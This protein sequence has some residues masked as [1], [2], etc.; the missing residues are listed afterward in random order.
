MITNKI[1]KLYDTFL[2][3]FSFFRRHIEL[4]LTLAEELDRLRNKVEDLEQNQKELIREVKR[5]EDV[6]FELS[7]SLDRAPKERETA[8]DLI[9]TSQDIMESIYSNYFATGEPIPDRE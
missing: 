1:L 5:L 6:C 8:K 9:R 3:R 7:A 2:A 4:L